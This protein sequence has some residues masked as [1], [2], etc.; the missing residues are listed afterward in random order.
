MFTKLDISQAYQQLQ[1]D[2]E[3]KQF[4]VVNTPKCLFKYNHVPFGVS[5]APGIFQR[6]MEG[7][8][9][10]I[11]GVV[12]CLD[13][14]L[15]TGKSEAKHLASLKEV[16]CM[17]GKSRIQ[18]EEKQMWIH[19]ALCWVSWIHNWCWMPTPSW[20]ESECDQRCSK[21]KE[22]HR[23]QIVSVTTTVLLWKI[24]AT[25]TISVGTALQATTSWFTLALDIQ[26]ESSIHESR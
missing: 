10:G 15:V 11:P 3:S 6:V 5:S 4:V 2:K 9:Q 25:F 19:A 20:E 8:L 18:T 1:L 24:H 14:I 23:A 17:S 13:D 12:V 21:S 7:I 16:L 26:R 22:C